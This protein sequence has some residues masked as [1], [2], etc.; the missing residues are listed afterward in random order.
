M[1]NFSCD[2]T[3]VQIKLNQRVVFVFSS[4]RQQYSLVSSIRIEL[5]RTDSNKTAKNL[6]NTC[7][8]PI[9]YL[10][11][12]TNQTT[13]KGILGVKYASSLRRIS[14]EFEHDINY[15]RACRS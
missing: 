15:L 6:I 14:L 12:K 7:A 3:L 5:L 2:V 10:L 13:W 4:N 8:I 11:V 9:I 1:F